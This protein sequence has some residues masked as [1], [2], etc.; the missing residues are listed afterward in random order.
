MPPGARCING[1]H[2]HSAGAVAF[3]QW[4]AARRLIDRG[5]ETAV[6]HA[7]ALGLMGRVGTWDYFAD[8]AAQCCL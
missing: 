4:R 2:L 1:S 7:A 5:A 8:R 3:G 6:W